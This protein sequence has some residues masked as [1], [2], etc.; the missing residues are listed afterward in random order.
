MNFKLLQQLV[1]ELNSS[2]STLDK[3]NVLS[4][5]KYN[6]QFI[7][8]VLVA[9]YNPYVK[10]GVTSSYLK[11]NANLATPNNYDLFELL[12]K[13]SSREIT[14]HEGISIVNGF[15]QNHLEYEELI[16]N[17]LDRNLK[18]RTTST[19]IN[20]V[21]KNLIP[22]FDVTLA[23]KYEDYQNKVNFLNNTWFASRKLDGL[24]CVAIIDALGDIE[25]M[26]RTG[27]AFNT[28]QLVIDELKK[29]NLTNVVFDGEICIVED[30]GIEN[31][32]A[33]LQE[34][35]KKN[36]TILNPR[37]KIFDMVDLKDFNNKKGE[38]LFSKRYEDLSLL[39]TNKISQVSDNNILSLVTQVPVYDLNH[40]D[41]L[42]LKATELG[43]EGMM[44]RKNVPYEA[45]RSDKLL[46]CKLF[47]EEEF[48]VK[49]VEF[50]DMRIIVG[51]DGDKRE[52]TEKMLTNVVIHYK[53]S[54]KV[55]VG[56]GFSI[57]ER[58]QFYKSPE[59]IIGKQITV[60]HFGESVNK[61]GGI[62]LR[63]PTLKAIYLDGD[64]NI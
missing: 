58:Q 6:N 16:Y 11:K 24:R 32:S 9:T 17:I 28:L 2:N 20:K 34:Y 33:I 10:Y 48:Y 61:N 39:F 7:K 31:F 49:D 3:V 21:Y 55:S 5:V 60:K 14:G 4:K 18:T 42:R 8:D 45:K 30:N 38:T 37:F 29:L 36:H 53:G 40:L 25:M 63:F 51:D 47:I 27:I 13:L 41:N 43:W 44:I 1:D 35:N 62:S 64:R 52:I 59:N 54:N 46:K 22:T 26:S 19:I 56:S 50:G 23:K 15:I 12:D 57:S